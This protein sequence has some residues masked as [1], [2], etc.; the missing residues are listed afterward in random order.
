MKKII[1]VVLTLVMVVASCS[2]AYANNSTM[3]NYKEYRN[4]QVDRA[5]EDKEYLIDLNALHNEGYNHINVI[6]DEATG[7]ATISGSKTPATNM[8]AAVGS[9]LPT[10]VLLATTKFQEWVNDY[11]TITLTCKA[12]GGKIKTYSGSA[13]VTTTSGTTLSSWDFSQIN[14]AGTTT[15]SD[16]YSA[17]TGAYTAVKLKITNQSSVD[18]YG[19]TGYIP[20]M[21][22]SYS[23]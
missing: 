15:L 9:S 16:E 22:A 11:I 5:I 20:D 3:T 4:V 1:S 21:T 8:S 7:K 2:I 23:R 18:I 13:K 10:I 19:R 14:N 6:V 12:T 17:Y